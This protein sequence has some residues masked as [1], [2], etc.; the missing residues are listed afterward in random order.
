MALAME[1]AG[2]L[3]S[4]GLVS[5][6]ADVNLAEAVTGSIVFDADG[7]PIKSVTI[8]QVVNGEHVVVAKVAG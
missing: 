6:L 4:A 2:S 7:N 8:I 3:D 1:N 5:A